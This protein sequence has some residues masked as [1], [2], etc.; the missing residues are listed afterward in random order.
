MS[1]RPVYRYP[2]KS[3][4]PECNCY[5]CA[6]CRSRRTAGD[7]LIAMDMGCLAVVLGFAAVSALCGWLASLTAQAWLTIGAVAGIL[8][9]TGI[10]F[11]LATRPARPPR[12][13]LHVEAGPR[14]LPSSVPVSPPPPRCPHLDAVPVD[15]STGERVAWLCPECN[16][17]LPAEF[18]RLRRPCCGTEHGR[19]HLGTCPHF[20]ERLDI[21]GQWQP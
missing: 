8:A 1:N 14:S 9:V 5:R 13:R 3:H 16:E 11:R 10:V 20:G 12:G 15:L 6:Q 19:R 4:A 2:P 7:G 17:E 21:T 18:G